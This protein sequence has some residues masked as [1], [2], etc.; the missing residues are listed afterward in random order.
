MCQGHTPYPPTE[1]EGGGTFEAPGPVSRAVSDYLA[2]CAPRRR[3][4]AIRGA[5]RRRVTDRREHTTA[6]AGS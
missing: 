5:I 4:G 3:R 2:M 1:I 6:I